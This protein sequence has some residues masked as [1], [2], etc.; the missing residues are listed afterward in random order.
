MPSDK[1]D[2]MDIRVTVPSNLIVASNRSLREKIVEGNRTTYCWHEKYP[3]ATYLV[4]LAIHPYEMFYDQY[5]YNNGADTMA[6]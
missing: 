4:S 3:I 1:P 5:I 2:S 6:I